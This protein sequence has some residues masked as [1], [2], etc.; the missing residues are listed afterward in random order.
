M[1][2]WSMH[3]G[4]MQAPGATPR[5]L[6]VGTEAPDPTNPY[7]DQL[8]TQVN[9]LNAE[10]QTGMSQAQA[11]PGIMQGYQNQMG[12]QQGLDSQYPTF[13]NAAGLGTQSAYQPAPQSNYTPVSS[14]SFNPWSMK[15]EALSR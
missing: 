3:G 7:L 9:A 1:G 10:T 13:P 15:G 12:Q 14:G 2:P 4:G 8:S 6:G 5:M 11:A